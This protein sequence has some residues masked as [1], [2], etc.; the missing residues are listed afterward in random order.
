MSIIPGL[1]D[2]CASITIGF[3]DTPSLLSMATTSRAALASVRLCLVRD[4]CF[5]TDQNA[6]SF[7]TFVI[8]HTLEAAM[9]TFRFTAWDGGLKALWPNLLADVLTRA[10]QLTWLELWPERAFPPCFFDAVINRT[11]ALTRLHIKSYDMEWVMALQGIRGLSVISL[12]MNPGR[13]SSEEVASRMGMVETVLA[14]NADTLEDVSLSTVCDLFEIEGK[15]IRLVLGE[16]RYPHVTRLTLQNLSFDLADIN[17]HFPIIQRF[18]VGRSTMPVDNS[19]A[20]LVW[21][22]L[23]TLVAPQSLLVPMLAHSDCPSLHCLVVRSNFDPL[24]DLRINETLDSMRVFNGVQELSFTIPVR[25]PRAD[26]S[27]A[28]FLWQVLGSVPHVRKLDIHL[29]L[30]FDRAE[31]IHLA[32]LTP[33]TMPWSYAFKRLTFLSLSMCAE[34]YTGMDMN[35]QRF[36]KVWFTACPNL[37]DIRLHIFPMEISWKRHRTIEDNGHQQSLVVPSRRLNYVWTQINDE[38]SAFG[39]RSLPACCQGRHNA[40]RDDIYF[41]DEPEIRE[42]SLRA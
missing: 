22:I 10:T 3:L 8:T 36:A 13:I 30:I 39:P 28:S 31:F 42:F 11:P 27:A 20:R 4:V 16:I 19:G 29:D 9:R 6:I 5:E 37:T 17:R 14:D 35:I 26:N 15:R 21:P 2:D 41:E 32:S 25:N 40:E 18:A 1:N 12:T 33:D 24:P 38:V 34:N 23:T 7:L